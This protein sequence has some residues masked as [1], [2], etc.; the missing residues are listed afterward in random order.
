MICF[1]NGE[2]NQQFT[3]Y[4][5]VNLVI[6]KDLT[7]ALAKE[8]FNNADCQFAFVDEEETLLKD[9]FQ[10][11]IVVKGTGFFIVNYKKDNLDENKRLELFDRIKALK[12]NDT[13]VVTDDS[14][15]E[16]VKN[17]LS[18]ISEYNPL[19]ISFV[20]NGT[21]ILTKG[22]FLQLIN[23]ESFNSTLLVIMLPFD[24]ILPPSTPKP[25]KKIKLFKNRS[26]KQVQPKH[27][28]SSKEKFYEHDLDLLKKNVY[29]FLFMFLF[30]LIQVISFM[31]ALA[32]SFKGDT[33]S[34]FLFVV[35]IAFVGVS[36]Y[37]IFNYQKTLTS[38][39]EY[40]LKNI[41]LLLIVLF[42]AFIA[43]IGIGFA[44]AYNVV[45]GTEEEP[46]NYGTIV[47]ISAVAS[48]GMLV[49]SFFVPEL[50]RLIQK[51]S[52]KE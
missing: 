14:Q 22:E 49:A 9:L 50:I 13:D 20:N 31:I 48:F 19:F 52:K 28:N 6:D 51:K 4:E 5:K 18:I 15:R 47:L 39:W 1:K 8:N 11:K 29:D 37:S 43:G 23:K 26:T 3:F 21:P 27:T 25:T 36:G 41:R 45:K 44:I 17:M 35:S 33:F 7:V 24:Y 30:A 34:I 32:L 46:L 40:S 2:T 42:L 12:N 10:I 38:K 16:K